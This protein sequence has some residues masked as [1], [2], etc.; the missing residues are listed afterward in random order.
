MWRLAGCDVNKDIQVSD[1][2]QLCNIDIEMKNVDRV[3][4]TYIKEM[5]DKTVFRAEISISYKASNNDSSLCYALKN[6]R[7]RSEPRDDRLGQLEEK[8]DRLLSAIDRD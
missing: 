2:I 8:I 6:I 5:E 1:R 3:F 4:R 7:N